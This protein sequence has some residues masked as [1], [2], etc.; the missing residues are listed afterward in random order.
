MLN[1]I[2]KLI[3][4]YRFKDYYNINIVDIN[5]SFNFDNNNFNFDIEYIT[6]YTSNFDIEYRIYSIDN[7][8][9]ISKYINKKEKYFKLYKNYN[10]GFLNDLKTLFNDNDYF[11][12][13][14]NID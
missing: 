2:Y 11:L 14:L 4:D 12:Y 9:I 1:R 10:N 13:P 6:L 3:K 8:I 5:R 7:Y